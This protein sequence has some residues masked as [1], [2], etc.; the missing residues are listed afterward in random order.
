MER[1]CRQDAAADNADVY[2]VGGIRV[3]NAET[4]AIVV[5][6]RRIGLLRAGTST[7]EGAGR[8]SVGVHH[9]APD[10]RVAEAEKM[11][12]LVIENGFEV[13]GFGRVGQSSGCCED[14]LGIAGVEINVGV[15]N[16]SELRGSGAAADM[17]SER[18]GSDDARESED[19]GREGH[20]GLIEA[21]GVEAGTARQGNGQAHIG[22]DLIEGCSGLPRPSGVN[23]G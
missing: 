23:C 17:F 6:K 4:G 18:V 13:V 20:V 11:A 10:G 12:E 22:D 15:E 7:I 1:I 19:S 21:D 5:A 14:D 3:Q 2:G 16:L 9:G 8:G